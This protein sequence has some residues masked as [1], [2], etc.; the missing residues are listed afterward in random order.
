MAEPLRT[1]KEQ[2]EGKGVAFTYETPFVQ[3][4]GVGMFNVVNPEIWKKEGKIIVEKWRESGMVTL[5]SLHEFNRSTIHGDLE[6]EKMETFANGIHCRPATFA[7]ILLY[8]ANF[9]NAQKANPIFTVDSGDVFIL[10]YFSGERRLMTYEIS[11]SK[12]ET[13]VLH[14][15]H[16]LA[17]VPISVAA[18][19][20]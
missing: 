19:V 5:P 12:P 13:N 3:M 20:R 16:R 11:T 8:A 4:V 1:E 7:E 6:P 18:G 14:N 10:D 9:P 2:K 15:K 17:V